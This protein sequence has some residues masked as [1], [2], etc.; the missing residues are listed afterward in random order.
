VTCDHVRPVE[1]LAI[2]AK[3]LAHVNLTA[4]SRVFDLNWDGS[5]LHPLV[6]GGIGNDRWPD[7]VRAMD[8]F[9][10]RSQISALRDALRGQYRVRSFSC[11]DQFLSMAF[12]Q[13]TYRESPRDIE[14]SLRALGEKLYHLGIRGSP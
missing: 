6:P 5:I 2:A 10:S 8:G 3:L 9:H 12:A 4:K 13:L 7:G 11:W 1:R 14:T